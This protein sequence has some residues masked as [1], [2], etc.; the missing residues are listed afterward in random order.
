MCETQVLAFSGISHPAV[1][2]RIVP[3]ASSTKSIT[4]VPWEYQPMKIRFSRGI[5]WKTCEVQTT[6]CALVRTGAR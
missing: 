5:C 1:W 6:A 2:Y 3:L 4:W